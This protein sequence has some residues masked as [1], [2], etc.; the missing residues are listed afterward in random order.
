MIIIGNPENRRV[1][2]FQNSAPVDWMRSECISWKSLFTEPN[3]AQQ[4]LQEASQIRIDSPGENDEVLHRLIH[5]GGQHRKLDHGEI[6]YLREQYDGLCKMLDL[7]ESMVPRPQS[8]SIFQNAPQDIK[9]MFDKWASHQ[10]FEAAKLPRPATTIAPPDSDGFRQFREQF[11]RRLF[12]KPRYSSSAS[13][14][15]AYR[16]CGDREQLIAPIAIRK[17][18]TNV[19]FFN[20]LKVRH[21]VKP[22]DINAIL[23]HLLPQGMIAEKWIRKQTISGKRFDFRI[24]VIAG[25]ARHIVARKSI[26]PMTNLHLGNER[27]DLAVIRQTIGDRVLENCN[28]LAERATQCFPNSLYAGVDVLVPSK[29]EPLICEINAFGD[30]LPNLLHRGETAYE[31]IWKATHVLRHS[32]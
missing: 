15:C 25:E 29:G 18:G 2:E 20:S 19:Q 17:S 16:W 26:H 23:N 30:L 10:R 7:I 21:Y 31:S 8:P 9:V 22:S 1:Q 3:L 5:C 13:G 4:R 28:R 32:V 12:L 14:V 27:A 6:G 11:S 24:L